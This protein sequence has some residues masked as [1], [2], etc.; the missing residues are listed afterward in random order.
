MDTVECKEA[1]NDLKVRISNIKLF[2]KGKR[3]IKGGKEDCK[4]NNNLG[5]NAFMVCKKI[6]MVI[7]LLHKSTQQF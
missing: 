2:K 1:C 7:G 4:Q 3:C 5:S 6:G